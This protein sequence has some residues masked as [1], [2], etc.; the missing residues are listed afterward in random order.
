MTEETAQIIGGL[1]ERIE[2]L[3][4]PNLRT[5]DPC[6]AW[7]PFRRSTE[8]WPEVTAASLS[9]ASRTEFR[10]PESFL[11]IRQSSSAPLRCTTTPGCHRSSSFYTHA[12]T[13]A[14][15]TPTSRS[16]REAKRKTRLL[17]VLELLVA[18]LPGGRRD[19]G[20]PSVARGRADTPLDEVTHPNEGEKR[21]WRLRPAQ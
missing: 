10:D 20:Q 8:R 17:E 11:A 19:R 18:R 3:R 15:T 5:D 6:G 12:V 1:L 7:L 9:V 16:R 13:A 2:R 14:E 21:E 4:N